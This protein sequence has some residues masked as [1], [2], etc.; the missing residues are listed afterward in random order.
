M[1]STS[2]SAANRWALHGF[3]SAPPQCP[4]ASADT[5]ELN[6]LNA[7]VGKWARWPVQVGQPL[8]AGRGCSTLGDPDGATRSARPLFRRSSRSHAIVPPSALGQSWRRWPPEPGKRW[9]AATGWPD[10][11]ASCCLTMMSGLDCSCRT[12]CSPP[13]TTLR[14]AKTGAKIAY[15]SVFSARGL[16]WILVQRCICAS[17]CGTADATPKRGPNPPCQTL[18]PTTTGSPSARR[19]PSC[20]CAIRR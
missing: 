2:G 20:W 14:V 9:S 13:I 3:T 19:R 15:D 8:F 12:S 16:S 18:C 4:P 10:I 6:D 5:Q 7:A 1:F 11:T 17:K